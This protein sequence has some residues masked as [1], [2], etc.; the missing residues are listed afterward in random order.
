MVQELKGHQEVEWSCF[1]GNNQTKDI[2]WN[3]G[4]GDLKARFH[5][6]KL[7]YCEKELKKD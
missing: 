2:K 6:I 3:K 1:Q 7:S 5:P 4:N